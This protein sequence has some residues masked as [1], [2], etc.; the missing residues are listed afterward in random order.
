[1]V[2]EPMRITSYL[3]SPK[4]FRVYSLFSGVKDEAARTVVES[5][6]L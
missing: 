2:A 1:M 5:G 6:G 3:D 4:T